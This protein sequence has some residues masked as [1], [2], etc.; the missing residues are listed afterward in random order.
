MEYYQLS[1]VLTALILI[2][3]LCH[4]LNTTME[5]Q[6]FNKIMIEFKQYSE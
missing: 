4:V 3:L 2:T 1:R 5:L 6:A